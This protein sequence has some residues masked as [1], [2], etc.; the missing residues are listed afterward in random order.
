MEFNVCNHVSPSQSLK[1]VKILLV[2][3]ILVMVEIYENFRKIRQ[4]IEQR[5][6]F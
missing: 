4:G 5:L 1:S 6:H 2:T 3:L